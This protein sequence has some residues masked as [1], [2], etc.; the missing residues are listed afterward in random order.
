MAN[1]TTSQ[2]P[3][4]F[5]TVEVAVKVP[6]D[7]GLVRLKRRYV[8]SAESIVESIRSEPIEF[9]IETLGEPD[10]HAFTFEACGAK[11]RR[12][13]PNNPSIMTITP[14]LNAICCFFM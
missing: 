14:S 2:L 5:T 10:T 13:H 4:P 3:C 7:I 8:L 9:K 11:G 1:T 6:I 12:G